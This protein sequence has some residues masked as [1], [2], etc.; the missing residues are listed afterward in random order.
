MA[1]ASVLFGVTDIDVIHAPALLAFAEGFNIVLSSET[2][3][4]DVSDINFNLGP[5]NYS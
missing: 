5:T 1:T 2:R 4:L 3:L